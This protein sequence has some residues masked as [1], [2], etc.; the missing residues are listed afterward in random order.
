[1]L[2]MLSW[3]VRELEE[4]LFWLHN[5]EK[6]AAV[7]RIETLANLSEYYAECIKKLD[8]EKE[9]VENKYFNEAEE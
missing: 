3:L 1:M 5:K 6:D 9:A 7:K 4:I 2:E 8:K